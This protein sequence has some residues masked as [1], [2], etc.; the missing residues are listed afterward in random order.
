MS[1][2]IRQSYINYLHKE[3]YE[4]Y[5]IKYFKKSLGSTQTITLTLFTII[6]FYIFSY[7]KK[8]SD[9]YFYGYLYNH[10]VV[11]YNNFNY[12]IQYVKYIDSHVELICT[13]KNKYRDDLNT[14]KEIISNYNTT[15]QEVIHLTNNLGL[16]EISSIEKY[17]ELLSNL[18]FYNGTSL[19]F[20][21]LMFFYY[22]FMIINNIGLIKSYI[23][24]KYKKKDIKDISIELIDDIIRSSEL[25]KRY[26][27]DHN[28][29][30]ISKHSDQDHS[31]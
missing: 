19:I 1:K 16:C 22:C 15:N 23:K 27:Y 6:L 12:G 25:I 8:E 11:S 29:I 9:K 13:I 10:N 5:V 3:Q 4:S 26:I 28:D 7:Y 24:N 14:T 21:S 18:S 31:V 17:N 2:N 30:M 20:G